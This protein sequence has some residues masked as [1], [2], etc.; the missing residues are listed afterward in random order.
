MRRFVRYDQLTPRQRAWAPALEW[1]DGDPPSVPER[2]DSARLGGRHFQR[3]ESLYLLDDGV[4][5]ARVGSVRLDFRSASHS[6]VVCGVA[7]VVTRPDVIHRGY[8]KALLVE[9]HRRARK[10]G[11]RWSYL[12]T[13]RSWGAHRLYEREGYRDVYSPA[14]AFRKIP[15]TSARW[16]LPGGFS[17]RQADASDAELLEG[18]LS[19]ATED[20]LGFVPRATGSFGVRF[21]IGWRRPEDFWILRRGRKPLGYAQVQTERFDLLCRELVLEDRSVS[22][23]LLKA[24]EAKAA[25]KWLGFGNTTFVEEGRALLKLNGYAVVEGTHGVLMACPLVP[26]S[27]GAW[28]ELQQTFAD[29]RFSLHGGD[30][31]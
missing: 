31:F 17:V 8:A 28:N 13:R 27:R 24:I 6:E 12:W 29:P 22:P 30:M 26:P 9:T 25:G 23:V 20:R 18:L 14:S 5:L 4:P 3:Y 7:D 2:I 10:E 19:Q 11:L 21:R 1:T 16:R 15:R